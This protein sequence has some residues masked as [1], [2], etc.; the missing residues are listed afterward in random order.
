MEEPRGFEPATAV[1]EPA[2]EGAVPLVAHPL[3]RG[4]GRSRQWPWILLLAML[5]HQGLAWAFTGAVRQAE[6][7]VDLA[8]L[9]GVAQ[10]PPR[11]FALLPPAA[12][13]SLEAAHSK[14]LTLSA[15]RREQLS[16]ALNT[17]AASARLL[18]ALDARDGAALPALA[19]EFNSQRDKFRVATGTLGQ[20]EKGL[21][22]SAPYADRAWL[23]YWPSAV[24]ALLDLRVRP[25]GA[26]AQPANEG[27]AVKAERAGRFRQRALEIAADELAR[28]EE[29]YGP[30]GS[31]AELAGLPSLAGGYEA[32]KLALA[33]ARLRLAGELAVEL[34]RCEAVVKAAQGRESQLAGLA[35]GSSVD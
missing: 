6:W 35:S 25:P 21:P 1:P 3:L 2:A 33:R 19:A 18:A 28:L 11:T 32:G 8:A 23:S 14:A 15:A 20:A 17:L 7:S 9:G 31:A 12:R 29:Q 5:A 22:A 13:S 24:V 16:E 30:I 4:A 10:W 34:G 27:L 26:A